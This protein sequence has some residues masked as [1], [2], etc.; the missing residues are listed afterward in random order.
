[1]S[2][3]TNQGSGH[4]PYRLAFDHSPDATAVLDA[5]GRVVLANPGVRNLPGG[6]VDRLFSMPP[7]PEFEPFWETLRASGAAHAEPVLGGRTIEVDGHVHGEH[8]VV[9]LR[10]VTDRRRLEREVRALR[11]LESMGHFTA[12]LVH[13]FNNL[14]TPIACLSA[15]LENELP[16]RGAQ[17]EMAR[18]IRAAAEKCAGL[19]RQVMRWVGRQPVH[20]E[21]L[22]LGAV[23]VEMQPLL[24]RVAGAEI[25]IQL[26][27]PG[28]VGAASVDRERLEHALLNLVANARD[29]MPLGGRITLSATTVSFDDDARAPD[30]VRPGAYVAI[31]VVDT[32]VGMKP[33]V[34]ERLFEQL[35][36]TKEPGR[37]TGLGLT[38][39]KQFVVESGG[40][41]A[42]QSEEGR[43]TTV[44]VYFPAAVLPSASPNVESSTEAH[45]SETV[46]VVDDDERVRDAMRTVLA[47]R[48]YRVLAAASGE[49]ALEL[50]R[51]G[52]WPFDVVI[53]D[54]AMPGMGGLELVRRL[55]E[56]RAT[57]V[58]FT[59]GHTESKVARSGLRPEDGPLLRK[60]FTPAE[61]LRS[62]RCVLD[63]NTVAAR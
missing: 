40:C 39:V 60:A 10:D 19:A 20:G 42:V 34:K 31:H 6:L 32:G 15:C 43:G 62:L 57:P 29:A 26:A 61:L 56:M 58:L 36:T 11:R 21:A 7:G 25:R 5:D 14:L 12:G 49:D 47:R 55:R 22:D 16:A 41:I 38:T 8:F 27:V 17:H 30:G 46:L 2:D 50:V 59:S 52:T 28:S 13:D 9:T 33:E 18:D 45:G 51:Q 63:V 23:L 37:G 54:V 24:E 48:G 3:D 53:A 44:S 1:M 4:L 35:F